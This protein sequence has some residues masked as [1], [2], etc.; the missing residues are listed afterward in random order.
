MNN[1]KY[2][3][4]LIASNIPNLNGDIIENIM[5][6]L[7]K[8]YKLKIN[9]ID[10]YCKK[11]IP[12]N[13]IN[14]KIIINDFSININLEKK[15]FILELIILK[16]K[17]KKNINLYNYLHKYIKLLKKTILLNNQNAG[18]LEENDDILTLDDINL[19]TYPKVIKYNLD[20]L[21]FNKIETNIIIFI[22]KV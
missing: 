10:N 11:I 9:K 6:D 8:K 19:A 20:K 7:E 14:N 21:E 17:I 5:N 22:K 2:L 3:L 4:N 16:N 13:I 1:I 15:I 12:H 18:S